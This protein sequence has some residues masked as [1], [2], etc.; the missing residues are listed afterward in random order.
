MGGEV[1]EEHLWL[2]FFLSIYVCNKLTLIQL[3]SIVFISSE[4]IIQAAWGIQ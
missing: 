4:A 2:S 1:F 3:A